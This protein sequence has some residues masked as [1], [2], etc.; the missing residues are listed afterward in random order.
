MPPVPASF[1]SWLLLPSSK[2]AACHHGPPASLL[3]GPVITLDWL[4]KPTIPSP[5]QGLYLHHISTPFATWG[6]MFAGPEGWG[7]GHFW[8]PWFCPPHHLRL[9]SSSKSDLLGCVSVQCYLGLHEWWRYMCD[10]CFLC[11]INSACIFVQL[12]CNRHC[13]KTVFSLQL[14]TLLPVIT[15]DMWNL[16]MRGPLTFLLT[17]HHVSLQTIITYWCSH[18]LLWK[19]EHLREMLAT[20]WHKNFLV[21][22]GSQPLLSCYCFLLFPRIRSLDWPFLEMLSTS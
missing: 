18:V 10:K 11:Q 9:C 8:G 15:Q 13:P 21:M 16:Q 3:P 7:C 6:D 22:V 5:S 19:V 2:T 17:A 1:S 20:R 12:E 4:E 14:N